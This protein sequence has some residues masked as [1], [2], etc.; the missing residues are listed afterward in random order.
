MEGCETYETLRVVSLFRRGQIGTAESTAMTPNMVALV[1]QDGRTWTVNVVDEDSLDGG[2]QPLE[3]QSDQ[4]VRERPLL[5]DLVHRHVD[6]IPDRRINIDDEGL[7]I[8]TQKY[9]TTI[10]SWHNSFHGDYDGII[11]HV[12]IILIISF[13]RKH[14]RS[15]N[16]LRIG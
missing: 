8:V 15:W 4:V 5:L 16:I 2:F 1:A 14:L 7:L 6:R 9:C 13:V 3:N 10:G 12:L 11:I